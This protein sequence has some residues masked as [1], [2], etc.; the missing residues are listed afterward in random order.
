[1]SGDGGVSFFTF[2]L[3]SLSGTAFFIK[4]RPFT[5]IFRKRAKFMQKNPHHKDAEK[6]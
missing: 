6:N 2:S 3:Y 5:D 1:M 4:T